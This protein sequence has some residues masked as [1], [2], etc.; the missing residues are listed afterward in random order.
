[1]IIT[2]SLAGSILAGSSLR[3]GSAFLMY[4]T[5]STTMHVLHKQSSVETGLLISVPFSSIGS[6]LLGQRKHFIILHIL[7]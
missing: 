4:L 3:I 5:H 7:H 1:M 2:L 6:A